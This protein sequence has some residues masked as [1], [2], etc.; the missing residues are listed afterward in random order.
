MTGETPRWNAEEQRWER[1]R[2]TRAYTPPPPPLPMF[3]PQPPADGSGTHLGKSTHPTA[4]PAYP[5]VPPGPGGGRR[6]GRTPVIAFA[7]AAVAGVAGLGVWLGVHRDDGGESAK[8]GSS[9]GAPA[10]TAPSPEDTWPPDASGVEPPAS[11]PAGTESATEPP[12]GFRIAEEPSG[13]ALAVPEKW[14]RSTEGGSVFHK[15]PD[16]R[17]LLQIFIISEPEMTP[18]GAVEAA[19]ASLAETNEGYRELSVGAVESGP[20]N[21]AADAAELHYSYESEKAGGVRECVD[22][23]FTA[24]NDTK[25]AVIACAPA[26]EA[27][28]QRTL[29]TTALKHFT[30]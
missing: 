15:A 16:G 12:A 18:L 3:P 1:S 17:S 19:S 23:A 27:P 6:L 4:P 5:L 9:S 21:P 30:T 25:Y 7:V 13:I 29:L 28:Y 22:R 20:E 2:R 14:K 24:A 8:R 11:S 26:D 10:S